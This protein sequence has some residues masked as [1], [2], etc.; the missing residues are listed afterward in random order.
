MAKALYIH[1]PFCLAKC[2]YCDFNSHVRESVEV[3]VWQEALLADMRHEAQVAGGE[4]LTSVFF[5]GGTPSLMPPALVETLLREAEALWGFAPNIEITLEANPSSVE[6][7][8][9]A[10]LASAGV[11]RVS[12]G[13]QSLDD[14]ALRFLGR[15]HNAQEGLNA[16]ETAQKA[17]ERVSFDLIYAL[18]DQTESEWRE[19]LA[20]ALGHGTGHLSLYQLTIEPG[21]RFATDVRRGG[22]TPLDDDRAADLFEL[23]QEMTSAAGLPAYEIS[24]HARPGEESRHNLTYWRYQDY[25][26]VGP[27]AHGRRGGTATMR[28]RKPENWLDAVAR[29]GHGL[30]EERALGVGEQLSEALLMGLRLAEGVDLEALSQRF[31]IPVERLVASDKLAHY[32]GLGLAWQDENRI[33]V[34]P[35]GMPLLDALLAELVP[36]ELVTA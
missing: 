16:L 7:A 26:G 2:P 32:A 17:F 29:N 1:W 27:G 36:D 34:T 8:N 35:A 23:T 22:F 33:G 15:L 20:R 13:L 5:G 31:A 30:K 9:F 25:C 28:H 18:P 24:N 4:A 6:A 3:D 21:T 19:Q 11:N 12:L 10:S 14:A